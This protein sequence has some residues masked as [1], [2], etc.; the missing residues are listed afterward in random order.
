MGTSSWAVKRREFLRKTRTTMPQSGTQTQRNGD[1][2]S[3][4]AWTDHVTIRPH[5][6]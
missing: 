3:D 5:F 6:R 1:E 2:V 4:S